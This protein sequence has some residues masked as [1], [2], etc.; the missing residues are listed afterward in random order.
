MAAHDLHGTGSYGSGG[1]RREGG[2]GLRGVYMAPNGT[3]QRVASRRDDGHVSHD[4]R[5]PSISSSCE[6]SMARGWRARSDEAGGEAGGEAVG[7]IAGW[8]WGMGFV[9]ERREKLIVKD[10]FL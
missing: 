8:G 10:V 3:T 4:Q 1:G 6:K 9:D 7:L 2:S 5:T